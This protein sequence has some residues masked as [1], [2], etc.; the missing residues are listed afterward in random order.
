MMNVHHQIQ[1][2]NPEMGRVILRAW[3]KTPLRTCFFLGTRLGLLDTPGDPGV[4]FSIPSD[5]C[6]PWMN[7]KNS[8]LLFFPIRGFQL[9]QKGGGYFE[10]FFIKL[11]IISGA[12]SFRP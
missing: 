4:G 9:L 10:T 12:R 1:F 3:S 8:S 11:S 5:G 2:T 7:E 6:A